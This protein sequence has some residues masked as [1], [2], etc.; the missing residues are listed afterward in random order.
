ME[1]SDLKSLHK[2]L[3][4]IQHAIEKYKYDETDFEKNRLLKMIDAELMDAIHNLEH[5]MVMVKE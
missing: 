2:E 1:H 4:Q 3:I 5:L